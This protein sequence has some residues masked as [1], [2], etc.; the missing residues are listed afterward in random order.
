RK[1]LVLSV[2]FG[3]LSIVLSSLG[4]LGM[5]SVSV[6]QRTKEIGIRKVMGASVAGILA[7]LGKDFL[8]LIGVAFAMAIPI[9]WYGMN[10][11]LDNF[12][13]RI[14]MDWWIF[15]LAGLTGVGITLVTLSFQTIRAA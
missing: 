8:K 2:T 3:G 10:R 5:I 7:L 13:D 1:A 4:L 14:E 15:V 12:A 6:Q 9:A 11:W